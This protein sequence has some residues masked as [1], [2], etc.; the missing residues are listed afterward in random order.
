MSDERTLY[1][2]GTY[3]YRI[4]LYQYVNIYGTSYVIIYKLCY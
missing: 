1:I 3:V 2:R 4:N